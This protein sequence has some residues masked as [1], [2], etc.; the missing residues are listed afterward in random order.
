MTLVELALMAKDVRDKQRKYFRVRDNTAL[1]T[2][3]E[4][5]RM[6]DKTLSEILDGPMLFGGDQ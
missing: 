4:A 3:K 6:L 2:S 1:Q 5:E